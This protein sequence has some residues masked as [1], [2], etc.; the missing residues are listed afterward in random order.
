MIRLIKIPLTNNQFD[1][2]VSFTFNLGSGAL[3]RSILRRK[4]NR[5][6]HE[7]VPDEFLHWIYAGGRK[8]PGL[9]RKRILEAELYMT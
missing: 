5:S 2:L 4:V 3:Q 6:E 1:S 9:V 8:I 7:Q